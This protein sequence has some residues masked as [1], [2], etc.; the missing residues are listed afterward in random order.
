MRKQKNIKTSGLGSGLSS[1]LGKQS[2]RPS[3]ISDNDNL[4]KYRMIPIE[5]IEPGP[6][7]PRKDFD[8]NE[9]ESLA[10]SIKNQGVIQP[11]I[12]KEKKDIKNEYYLIAG[13]RRWRASQIA[14][15]HQ[16]PAIV[17]N[18]L[19]EEKVAE[20]SLIENIQRSELNSLEEA[21]GYQLLTKKYNYT[22]EEISKAVGKSRPYIANVSRLLSLSDLAKKYLIQKKLTVGQLRPLIGQEDCDDLLEMIY[23]KKLNARQVEKLIKEKQKKNLEQ[24]E[25]QIDILELEKELLDVTGLKI[26]INFNE[27][28]QSGNLNIKCKSLTEFNYIISKIKS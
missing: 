7:Q 8:K 2:D 23:K 16:I 1:L 5:L 24:F 26:A 28:K 6:W 25:K 19:K 21:E 17:R 15:I 12:I 22:Q 11:V 10:I 27:K 14:K 13:E 18:D 20:L 4:E 9:L 3:L